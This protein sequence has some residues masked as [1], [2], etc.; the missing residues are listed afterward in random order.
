MEGHDGVFG[1]MAD[2]WGTG[3]RPRVRRS[4]DRRYDR[5]QNPKSKIDR[6]APGR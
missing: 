1:R 2:Q 4:A 6:L 3:Q 5:I